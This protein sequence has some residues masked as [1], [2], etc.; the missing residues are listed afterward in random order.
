M[1][2]RRLPSLVA[3]GLLLVPPGLPGAEPQAPTPGAQA[4]PHETP[5]VFPPGVTELVTV[6]VAVT[7]KNGQPVTGLTA[8]DFKVEM[9]LAK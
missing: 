2:H 1:K 9:E 5:Q 7:D 4:A 8:G 3:L 6:D